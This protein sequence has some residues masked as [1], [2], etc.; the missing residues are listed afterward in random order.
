M[1]GLSLSVVPRRAGRLVRAPLGAQLMG[2]RIARRE[3]YRRFKSGL[4]MRMLLCPCSLL[5]CVVCV[6]VMSTTAR[7]HP[8]QFRFPA[9]VR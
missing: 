2:N 3:L 6:G 7:P 8:I 5:C 4:L 9:V 1:S